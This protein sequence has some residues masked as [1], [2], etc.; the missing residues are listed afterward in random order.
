MTSS[1]DTLAPI[2]TPRASSPWQK[3]RAP[4]SSSTIAM[5]RGERNPSG[6][7]CNVVKD[8]TSPT[9]GMRYG[10]IATGW[11]GHVRAGGAT[12]RRHRGHR[13]APIMMVLGGRL[14][15]P[16][17]AKTP[18]QRSI[19]QSPLLAF[20]TPIGSLAVSRQQRDPVVG[21]ESANGLGQTNPC[22]DLPACG[23][24]AKLPVQLHDLRD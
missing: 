22:L 7:E 1:T 15:P 16:S 8:T 19:G 14:R 23:E 5:C 13:D 21:G 4:P 6:G 12:T 11:S 10:S 24:P 17:E 20:V 9:G 2:P 18:P 3:R